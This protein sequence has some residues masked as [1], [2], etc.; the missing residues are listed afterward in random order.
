M[1]L[2]SYIIGLEIHVNVQLQAKFKNLGLKNF[3]LNQPKTWVRV[4]VQNFLPPLRSP[5]QPV[6]PPMGVQ[7]LQP[8]WLELD[9]KSGH[10]YHTFLHFLFSL[11]FPLHNR[12]SRPKWIPKFSNSCL[13]FNKKTDHPRASLLDFQIFFFSH[14]F[15]SFHTQFLERESRENFGQS[16]GDFSDFWSQKPPPSPKAYL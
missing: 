4:L 14:F 15:L 3:Y 16:F 5:S 2:C 7:K 8:P 11:S 1:S 6:S 13:W 12:P 9:P 10:P